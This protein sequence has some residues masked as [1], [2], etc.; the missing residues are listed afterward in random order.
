M[1]GCG[2]SSSQ[3]KET[4]LQD[5]T[6][7]ERPSLRA[8]LIETMVDA[9]AYDSA[10]PLLRQALR[11]QPKSAKIHYLLAV[12][13]RERGRLEQAVAEFKVALTSIRV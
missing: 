2:G 13:L 3:S 6:P 5:L 11:E 10:V 9:K 7:S 8:S 1:S 12:V 4:G